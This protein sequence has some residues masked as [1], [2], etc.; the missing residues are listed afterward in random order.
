MRHIGNGTHGQWGI[1]VNTADRNEVPWGMGHMGN[2]VHGQW[3]TWSC[4][5]SCATS[6]ILHG[7]LQKFYCTQILMYSI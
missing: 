5:G 2:G 4:A 6:L 7:S 1:V 3:G